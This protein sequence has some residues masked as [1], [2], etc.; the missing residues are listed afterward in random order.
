MNK[1]AIALIAVVVVVGAYYFITKNNSAVVPAAPISG[2][3]TAP[4][5]S[6]VSIQ[7][8]SFNPS[9]L[10]VKTGTKVT[11]TNNDSVTHTVTLDSNS[12]FSSQTIAPGQSFSFTFTNPETVAY[13]CAIHPMMKGTVTVRN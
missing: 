1:T 10:S 4:L 11:W 3:A 13:H 12:L 5:D 8:F 6:T 9:S 2:T 7:N